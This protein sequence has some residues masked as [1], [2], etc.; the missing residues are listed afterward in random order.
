MTKQQ[1]TLQTAL[2]LALLAA[3]PFT[4]PAA[5]QIKPQVN[6]QNTPAQITPPARPAS[7]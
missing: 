2:G 6:Q 5:A 3:A 7:A 4:A 1:K